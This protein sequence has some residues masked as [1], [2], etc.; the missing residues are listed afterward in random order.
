MN[1]ERLFKYIGIA[2]IVFLLFGI[3]GWYWYI[4]GETAALGAPDR[5]RGFS[6]G[7]PSF[8]GSRG[9]NSANSG[10]TP[11]GS[12]TVQEGAGGAASGSSAF[13]RFLGIGEA[14][15]RLPGAG[16]PEESASTS[17]PTRKT[18]RFWRV[19]LAPVAGASFTAGSSTRLRYIERGTGY[20]FDVNPE[21]G[22][23]VR[24]T[25]TLTPKVYEAFAGAGDVI[26]ER[27]LEEGR[28]VTLAGKISTTTEDGLAQLQNANLGGE[29]GEITVRA[30]SEDILTLTETAGGT[31]LVRSRW[32]G[33]G[34]ERIITVPAGDFRV[35][36][37]AANRIVLVE[38]AASGIAGSAFTATA[39]LTPLVTDVLGLTIL[40]NPADGPILFSSDDGARVRLFVRA[41]GA[42]DA[43]LPITTIAEKC[44]WGSATVAYC[45]VPQQ[46]PGAGFLTKWYRGE[47]H[48]EDVWYTVDAGAA[49]ADKLF[50][51]DSAQAIDVES[52][53]IDPGGSYITFQNARDKSLWMLRI[54]E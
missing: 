49:K 38:K 18:P 19:S 23:A 42:S 16:T 6:I 4:K 27:I 37:P 34:A 24:L 1:H 31:N 43:E 15:M 22:E 39:A 41:A 5:A 35:L 51:I 21:S 46:I 50:T 11:S 29:I 25:N 14:P 17:A 45:A 36:W 33:A 2:A 52:P 30:D 32:S 13:L 28:S 53:A 7:I 12:A 47:V 44:V 10:A 26:I 20:V 54:A 40:P 48:T 8:L 9:S 3:T